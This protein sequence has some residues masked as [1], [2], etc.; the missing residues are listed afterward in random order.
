LDLTRA[1]VELAADL[2]AIPSPSDAE[3]VLADALHAALAAQPHLE[4]LRDGDTVIARTGLDRAETVI[5]GGHLDTVPP[6]AP[7]THPPA[8]LLDGVLWGRGSVDM[9]GGVAVMA[10]LAA[11]LRAPT[12]DVTW[13]FYDHEEVDR[14]FN[15]LRRIVER[16]PDWVSGTFAVLG[17]PTNTRLEGGCNGSLRAEVTLRGKAAHSARAWL[18]VNAIHAAAPVLTRLA[19]HTPTAS[20]VDGLTYPESLNA[21][22]IHGGVA[23]NVIPDRCT[24]TVNYRFAPN[25]SVDDAVTHLAAVLAPYEVVVVDAAPGARP[26]LAAAPA[27]EFA[28]VVARHGGGAPTAKVGWTDV[29]QFA[30]LGIPAVNC[31]PGDPALAHADNEHC[32]A[33]Q[34]DTYAAILREWLS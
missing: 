31:G 34:I 4:V 30:E 21:V 26:G 10:H 29:A 8:G 15:G 14:K 24:V 17:E 33:S 27:Q 9:K 28:Q 2:V 11:T 32:P 19:A 1:P 7:S 12:R 3:G 16:H 22:L 20:H 5:V 25:K 6:P 13:V 18:G 23:G